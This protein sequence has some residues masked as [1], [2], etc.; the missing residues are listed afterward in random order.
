ME[1]RDS[2]LEFWSFPEAWRV[3]L[4]NFSP[5]PSL[6]V[7]PTTFLRMKEMLPSK[8]GFATARLAQ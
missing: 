3:E 2:G 7:A 5:S 8:V 1:R 4:E 6:K